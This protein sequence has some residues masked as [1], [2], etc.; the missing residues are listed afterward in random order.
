[1]WGKSKNIKDL[2]ERIIKL[3]LKITNLII[4]LDGISQS[5]ASMRGLMNRKLYAGKLDQNE[6]EWLTSNLSLIGGVQKDKKSDAQ[7]M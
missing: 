1:M 2:E 3:E 4:H 7:P 5:V 6:P